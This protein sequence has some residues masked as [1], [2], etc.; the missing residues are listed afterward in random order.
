MV[1][2][3]KS[4]ILEQKQKEWDLQSQGSKNPKDPRVEA[5]HNMAS[6][7]RNMPKEKLADLYRRRK[8]K[9]ENSKDPVIMGEWQAIKDAAVKVFKSL[10][11]I[12]EH[13]IKPGT[14]VTA[15][16]KGEVVKGK[17][18]SDTS[19]EDGTDAYK[20]ILDVDGEKVSVSNTAIEESLA[21]LPRTS[22]A[23]SGYQ[24]AYGDSDEITQDEF[25]RAMSPAKI[26]ARSLNSRGSAA[27]YKSTVIKGLEKLG[28]ASKTAQDVYNKAELS[29]NPLNRSSSIMT[30]IPLDV[31]YKELNRR[32]MAA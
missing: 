4:H 9:D 15:K 23:S 13:H 27:A 17:V 30:Y 14:V 21:G 10:N 32:G 12:R 3:F 2:R 22:P 19:S 25:M 6:S 11:N 29:S 8:G 20:Y 7:L 5:Y 28:I 31:I 26:V 16:Y 18:L 1:Q 24:Y